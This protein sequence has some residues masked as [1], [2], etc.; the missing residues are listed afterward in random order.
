VFGSFQAT[1]TLRSPE[2]P[3]KS[4]HSPSFFCSAKIFSA[5]LTVF[6]I[7][8]GPSPCGLIGSHSFVFLVAYLPPMVGSLSFWFSVLCCG[9]CCFNLLLFCLKSN[10][11]A[12]FRLKI[13][14]KVKHFN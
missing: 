9:G 4:V 13:L 7:V 2:F 11:H 1:L 12:E 3:L 8:I 5:P 14:R 10:S 6:D